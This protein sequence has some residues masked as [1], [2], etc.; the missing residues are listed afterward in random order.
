[1]KAMNVYEEA[2]R[3]KVCGRCIERTGHGIC[4]SGMMEECL[5]NQ[6]MQEILE[7]ARNVVIRSLDDYLRAVRT[8]QVL[9]SRYEREAAEGPNVLDARVPGL[10]EQYIPDIIDAVD[11][12]NKKKGES[13]TQDVL[14]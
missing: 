3:Q 12:L 1:M 14:L 5:L 6:H 13:W 10:L 9:F 4:G 11:R 7:V 2:I 8:L